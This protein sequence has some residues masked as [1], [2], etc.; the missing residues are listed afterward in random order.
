[1][2]VSQDIRNKLPSD[3][4]VFDNHSYDNSIIGTTFDGRAIYDFD[5]MVK[6]LMSD[7]GWTEEEAIEWVNY[8]TLRSLPYAGVNAPLIVYTDEEL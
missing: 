2:S 1:M 7:E 5:K 4:V 6:E 8:N 3:A